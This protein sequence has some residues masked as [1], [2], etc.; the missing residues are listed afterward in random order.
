MQ[1]FAPNPYLANLSAVKGKP[2]LS[3]ATHTYGCNLA[4]QPVK[5][6]PVVMLA[7][8]DCDRSAVSCKRSR[9]FIISLII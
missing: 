9:A 3:A 1:Y 6:A 4:S 2:G 5:F 8:A 7:T